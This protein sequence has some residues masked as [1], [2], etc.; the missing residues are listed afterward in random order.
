MTDQNDELL[1]E[2][3]RVAKKEADKEDHEAHVVELLSCYVKFRPEDAKAWMLYGDALR[4]LGR[5]EDALLALTQAFDM[6]PQEK[7]GYAAVRMAML[8]EKHISPRE[9]KKWYKIATDILGTEVG[10]AWVFRGAN[11]SVLGEFQDAIACFEVVAMGQANEKDEALLNL[12]LIHRAMGEYDK[13]MDFFRKAFVVNPG[14]KEAR[15]AFLGLEKI[16]NTFGLIRKI[17]GSMLN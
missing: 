8:L 14:Y 15:N 2:I 17:N 13:A 10:W 9:A 16:S 12:G 5:K 11:L 3:Y 4:I 1:D 7:K 6:A